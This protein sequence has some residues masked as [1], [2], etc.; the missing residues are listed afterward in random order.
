MAK[1]QK[2]ED[3]TEVETAATEAAEATE[4]PAQV[5]EPKVDERFRMVK[6]PETGEMVKRKDYILELWTQKRMSRGDI[7]KHLTEITGKKVPYQIVFSS[8]K[9][10]EGGPVKTEAPAEAPAE[11]T[12]APEAS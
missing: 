1:H 3:E 4:A 7:A 2:A 10:I 11:A 9:G 5:E 8:T 6:R 12:E